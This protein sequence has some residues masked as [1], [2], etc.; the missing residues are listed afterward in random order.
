MAKEKNKISGQFMFLAGGSEMAGRIRSRDWSCSPLG[1]IE[2]W[3]QSLRT[4]ISLI[5]NTQHPMWVGWGPEITFFYND[6]YISVLSLAKHPQAL[7]KPCAELWAEVWDIC[8]PLT[9]KVYQRGEASFMNDVRFFMN[10]GGYLEETYYSFSYSP[11][12]DESGKVG[13]LFCP[14][15]EVTSK[16]L[17][18]RRLRTL[19]EL[20]A[21]SYVEKSATSACASA[22]AILRKNPDDIPFALLY[23]IEK[24]GRSARL[25][26]GIGLKIGQKDLCPERV[27]LL[28]D[29]RNAALWPIA[30]VWA[31]AEA[32]VTSIKGRHGF[33]LG[34]A[35]QPLGEAVVLPV[36]SRGQDRPLGI[37][38]CGVNPARWL[39]A[40][41]RTFYELVAGHIATAIQNARAAEEDKKRADMLAELDRAKTTFFSNVS[42]ELRTPLTLILG[43]LE[44]EL[45]ARNGASEGLELAYRNSL[46]LL[47]LVNTLLDFS[48][49]EAGRVEASFVPTDLAALTAEL[50]SV[51]RSGVE[52]A[53]LR[54]LVD[55][56]PLPQP[57]YVDVDMWEK[58]VFNLLSNA[59][60]FTFEGRIEISLRLSPGPGEAANPAPN[61]VATNSNAI[62]PGQCACLSVRDTGT[63]IPATELP[64]IFERFHRV[65]NARARS[66][67]GTGIGLALV[68]ELARQH[69]GGIGV[70]SVEGAGTTFTV[71]IP[72]GLAHLPNDRI[73][74][75]RTLA[76]TKSGALPFV[77]EALR[78]LPESPCPPHF[79]TGEGND[80]SQPAESQPDRRNGQRHGARILLADDNA[81]M[82]DY[83]RRLL[84]ARGHEVVAVENGE[85]ALAAVRAAPPALVLSDVMMPQLDG[86]GLLRALR[87]DPK[88][89]AIP[90]ILISARAGEEARAEGVE[91]GADDYLTKPFSARELIARV[92]THLDLNRIRRESEAK[93]RETLDSITDG[94]HKVD[95]AGRIS[96]LNAAARRT[97]AENHLDPDQLI[98]RDFFAVFPE[99]LQVEVGRALKQTLNERVPTAAESFYAPWRRWYGVRNYPTADGGVSTFFQDITERK[100]SEEM[101][102]QNEALFSSLV[103][104][105][106]TGVYVVDAQFRLQQINARARPAFQKVEPAVGR[107][108]AEVMRVLWG[109]EV[110]GEIIEIFQ[111]TLR[112]G[113]PYVSPRFSQ[114]RRDLGEQKT[115]EWETK[116]M[117]LPDGQHGVVCYFNDITENTRAEQALRDA[118]AAAESA[119]RS[120]DRFL[121]ALSHELR[122]PLT[123]V[124]VTA[125][126]L[127]E[128]ERLPPDMREQL[129]M[130]ERHIALEAR[131]IDDLLDLS[132]IA[133]GKLHLH[134]QLCDTRSLIQL[135]IEIVR[136][137]ALTKE[138]KLTC[139]LN[140]SHSGLLTDPARFQQII[141][142]LLR[143]AVKFT[144]R[145]GKITLRT[146]NH[147][148]GGNQT[149]LRLEVVDSGIGI[150]PN[151][152]D[153]I[154][155]PFEQGAVA[156]DHR[157]GGLGLGLAIARAIV[158]LHDGK[159]SAYSEGANL[160]ATFVVEL[161]GA[162]LPPPASAETN[163]GLPFSAAAQ[164]GKSG[165]ATAAGAIR[166]IL[167]VE[168]HPPSL[169]VLSTLLSRSGYQVIPATNVTEALAQATA[170]AFDLVISDLGLPDGTGLQLMAKLRADHGL[171]GIALTGYGMEDDLVRAREAGFIAHMIKP[172]QIAELRRVLAS[173][174]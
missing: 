41:Y 58:I 156:G 125:A 140:A 147:G 124:L 103:N 94:L 26:Q 12:R 59:F 159:I 171:R 101:L 170:Q 136:D 107:D 24:E 144:P 168:D 75:A 109:P 172:I 113:E 148:A 54:L 15:T 68:Q 155:L 79:P 1:P 121:A 34:A 116:R 128:D 42:H 131:L 23:L 100:Q 14:T 164:P 110:G 129:V 152:L 45:R 151:L 22:A 43:P 5:L 60:K 126:T 145:G 40:D 44:D 108:F 174:S 35:A 106:P 72:L 161:P 3:P 10:R 46:R 21:K 117:T 111:R 138:I 120:K 63:G 80:H 71:W 82:R 11:I 142:N 52:R 137:D 47:K 13:G 77:E 36:I 90:I 19:S 127:R 73:G 130:M 67:E 65:R 146:S 95:A 160:G 153:K 97:I 92:S 28:G 38:I 61:P 119:N 134:L 78:W 139:D 135:A 93:I 48:R 49:I 141:W 91:A 18:T 132:A 99:T 154:F 86:F 50:A 98:G 84:V 88:T 76:P 169:Q 29:Q 104:L 66:H 96:Y 31:A 7:G 39:D 56:P 157:F 122:T 149:W 173:L 143:N 8:G 27:E 112:T 30:K 115:Y 62:P 102:R 114:F 158:N 133:N 150:E 17:Q 70:E 33:P 6:A 105:A 16:V 167:L 162:V 74:A 2:S 83:V 37:L 57:V 9:E 53:G 166:R 20:A 32:L 85:A 55:C 4:A 25:E 118:K 123:P 81:D 165:A 87:G 51:F 64:R 89:S 163:P 69:G